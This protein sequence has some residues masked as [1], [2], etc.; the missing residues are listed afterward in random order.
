M[1]LDQAARSGYERIRKKLIQKVQEKETAIKTKKDLTSQKETK[2]SECEAFEKKLNVMKQEIQAF[3]LSKLSIQEETKSLE[4]EI[5]SCRTKKEELSKCYQQEKDVWSREHKYTVEQSEQRI[6]EA[7]EEVAHQENNLQQ[8]RI[9]VE[10]LNK[11]LEDKQREH[12]FYEKETREL[13]QAQ[14]KAIEDLEYELDL[15]IP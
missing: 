15:M 12:E 9:R 3:E 4:S 7:Q 10:E 8:L 13:Q 1:S 6:R 11:L 5:H 14:L 2:F